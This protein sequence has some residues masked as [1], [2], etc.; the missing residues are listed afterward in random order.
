MG[1]P[2]RAQLVFLTMDALSRDDIVKQ[3]RPELGLGRSVSEVEEFQNQVLRPILKFQNDLLIS[4]TKYYLARHHKNF[5]AL[6][7][8]AQET[9][10]IQASKQD[11]ELRNQLIYPVVSL[12][13]ED[14][15]VTYHTHRAELNKRIAQMATERVRSQMER[16]Y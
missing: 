10:L 1:Q 12:L 2:S 4:L 7:T 3:L 15:L 16:L 6:K 5:N 8:S 11:P 14:E 9:V 13:T